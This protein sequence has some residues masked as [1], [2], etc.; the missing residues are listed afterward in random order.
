MLA[1]NLPRAQACGR[2]RSGSCWMAISA[3]KSLFSGEG[4]YFLAIMEAH[5]GF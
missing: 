1:K 2:F 5:L 4:I 3:W